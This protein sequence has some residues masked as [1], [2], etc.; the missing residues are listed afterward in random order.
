MKELLRACEKVCMPVVPPVEAL[1]DCNLQPVRSMAVLRPQ[2]MYLVKGQEVLDPNP[3]MFICESA[4]GPSL[5][6]LCAVEESCRAQARYRLQA[7]PGSTRLPLQ[8]K[9]MSESFLSTARASS[10]TEPAGSP[11]WVSHLPSIA[12]V[13]TGEKWKPKK[14][15]AASLS[16]RGQGQAPMHRKYETW[17]RVALSSDRNMAKT[18]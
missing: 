1:L 17:S 3:H 11:P 16:W 8:S 18:C 4:A 5:R 2:T 9:S 10:R 13:Q 12:Q 14:A 7:K 6:N 15:I